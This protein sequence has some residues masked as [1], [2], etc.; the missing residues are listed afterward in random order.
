MAA[1]GN[2]KLSGT[3]DD[4]LETVRRWILRFRNAPDDDCTKK[5][6]KGRFGITIARDGT[7]LKVWLEQSSGC[8]RTD[9]AALQMA[10]NASPVP[11]LPAYI[12]GG[13]IDVGMPFDFTIGFFGRLLH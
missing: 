7:L 9:E 13:S 3:S 11:P 5:Q 4:Y 10:R 12:V 8:P 6:G 1:V 2:G